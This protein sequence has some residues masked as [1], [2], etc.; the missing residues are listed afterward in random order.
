VVI[1]HEGIVQFR[2]VGLSWQRSANLEDA[3]RKHI[4]V[5]AKSTEAQ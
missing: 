1:D 5:V 2:S 4:K 3:I